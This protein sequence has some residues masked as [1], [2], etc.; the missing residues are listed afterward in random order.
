VNTI[1]VSGTGDPDARIASLEQAINYGEV[2]LPFPILGEAEGAGPAGPPGPP[3]ETG[4]TGATGPVGPGV[5]AGGTTGQVLTK[6]SAADYATAWAAAGGAGGADEVSVGASDPGATFEL[7]YDTDATAPPVAQGPEGPPGPQG[8]TGPTGPPGVQGPTG[9]AGADGATGPQ[10]PPGA[11]GAPGPQGPQGPQGVPGVPPPFL[12]AKLA[13]SANKSIPHNSVTI[14]DFD[15]E[16][17]DTNTLHD[18][19]TQNTRLTCRTAGLYQV[20][21][22][23]AFALHATGDRFWQLNRNG[24]L[25]QYFSS[26]KPAGQVTPFMYGATVL[27]LAVG[28]YVEMG[29]FQDSGAPLNLLF[30]PSGQPGTE[31]G[32]FKVGDPPP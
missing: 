27:Q 1:K 29:V 24:V 26:N 31:F 18:T 11:D 5:P 6:S 10:G 16:R 4:A 17:F 23:M 8:A 12:G 32:M 3:G 15:Q 19:V 14:V 28:D 7:W 22:V 30:A 20:W 2:I 13:R 21:A 25:F 9:P